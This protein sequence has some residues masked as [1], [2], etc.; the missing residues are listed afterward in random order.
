MNNN[1]NLQ[2]KS[3]WN[4]VRLILMLRA[5][6]V[7]RHVIRCE[8]RRDHPVGDVLHTLAL[9]P[10]RR[11]LALR[12]RVKNQLR[13][14]STAR[15]PA[16]PPVLPI[17]DI[18]RRQI[19]LRHAV[20]QTPRQM[21]LRQPLLQRRRHQK[22]LLTITSYEGLGHTG[23]VSPNPD[24]PEVYETASPESSHTGAS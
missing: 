17:P 2:T 8:V 22:Y 24:R 7:D 15:T 23:I 12:V 5:K 9:D 19:H 16:D 3:P 1:Q 6:P 13:P 10:S 18:E 4:P 20:K 21:P 11:P 14:S